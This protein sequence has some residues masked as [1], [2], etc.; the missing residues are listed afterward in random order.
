IPYVVAEGSHAPKRAG[1]SWQIGHRGVAEALGAA[2]VVLGLNPADRDC[3]LPLLRDHAQWI[4]LPPFLD[5]KRYALP[6]HYSNS[7]RLIAVAMLRPG[8]KL[9]SYRLLGAALVGLLDL[10]WSLDVVG[11]GPAREEVEA[12]LAPLGRRVRYRGALD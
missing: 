4:A 11:D 1:G 6:A 8:D 7:P 10:P 5:A 2:D 12:A 9:A 3:V